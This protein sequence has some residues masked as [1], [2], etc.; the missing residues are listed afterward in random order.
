MA[1]ASTNT[2]SGCTWHSQASCWCHVTSRQMWTRMCEV[3]SVAEVWWWHGE[4]RRCE[5]HSL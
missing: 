1:C 4:R 5:T 2:Q 3:H